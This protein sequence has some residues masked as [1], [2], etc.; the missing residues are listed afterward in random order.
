MS[1][2]GWL[3]QC[4]PSQGRGLKLSLPT[5]RKWQFPYSFSSPSNAPDTLAA[6]SACNGGELALPAG[7]R[8]GLVAAVLAREEVNTAVVNGVL[9]AVP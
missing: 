7:E 3:M 6:G 5:L 4:R 9:A 2:A 8:V 1:V